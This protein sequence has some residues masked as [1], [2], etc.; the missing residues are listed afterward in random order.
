MAYKHFGFSQHEFAN[1][2]I[3]WCSHI[4]T[5]SLGV[6]LLHSSTIL[7]RLSHRIFCWHRVLFLSVKK[8]KKKVSPCNTGVETPV[9]KSYRHTCVPKF[10][11]VC[12]L[13][14]LNKKLLY[15]SLKSIT[16]YSFTFRENQI[17]PFSV[18]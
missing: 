14:K 10:F 5:L 11:I 12:V 15:I 1:S 9:I 8:K 7:G 6:Q 4:I 13:I 16:K 17:K 3:N 2:H 18:V